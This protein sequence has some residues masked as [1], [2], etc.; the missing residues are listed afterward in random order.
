MQ[1]VVELKKTVFIVNPN[2]ANGS[3]RREWPRIEQAARERFPKMEVRFTSRSYEAPEIVRQALH[4]GADC[5]VSV[6]GDGTHNEVVNGFFEDDKPI[7][8]LATLGILSR[9]TGGDFRKTLGLGRCSG[10]EMI[11]SIAQL[12]ACRVA[13]CDVGK[14][15]Y[16]TDDGEP[17]VRYFLNITSFGIGG[18]VDRRVNQSTKILGGK[19][20]FFIGSLRA[21]F[22]YKNKAVRVR[23]DGEDFIEGPI[24]NVAVANGKYFGGGMFVAPN[25][26][27]DDGLFD[28]VAC[29]DLNFFE[30]LKLGQSIYDG[31][32]LSLPKITWRRAKVVEAVSDQ[33]VLLDVDGEAPG[34]LN[35]RMENLRHAIR[36]LRM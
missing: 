12:A 19:A 36:V 16:H 31:S 34:K 18:E 24:Y 10:S 1:S 8:A 33:N 21:A 20:S 11:D 14:M 26:E 22:A 13:P 28:V 23:C 2:S 6:G 7:N 17:A 32:H 3:T 15:Q 9:G 27:I 25:A 29:G 35:V 30:S 4:D 5:I